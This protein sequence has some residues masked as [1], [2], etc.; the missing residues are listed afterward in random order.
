MLLIF[1]Y[2]IRVS[3]LIVLIKFCFDRLSTHTSTNK[4]REGD[5]P[6]ENG[7]M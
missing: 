5:E 1:E 2:K 4:N 7:Y 6:K 3:S